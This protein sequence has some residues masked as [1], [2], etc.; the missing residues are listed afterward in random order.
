V[1]SP[2]L[3]LSRAMERLCTVSRRKG[4]LEEQTRG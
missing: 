2:S 1:M 4:T 3:A